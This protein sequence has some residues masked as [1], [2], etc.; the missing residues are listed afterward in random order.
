MASAWA[1][2]AHGPSEHVTK[3]LRTSNAG[4]HGSAR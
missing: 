1:A 3:E 4:Q 2:A